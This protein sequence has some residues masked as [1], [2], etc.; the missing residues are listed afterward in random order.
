MFNMKWKDERINPNIGLKW[1]YWAKKSPLGCENLEIESPVLSI[2]QLIKSSW[3]L[4][5]EKKIRE[6]RVLPFMIVFVLFGIFWMPFVLLDD[7][8]PEI[9]KTL[10]LPAEL[11]PNILSFIFFTVIFILIFFVIPI[12]ILYSFHV[13]Q[14]AGYDQVFVE[15]FKRLLPSLLVLF[16]YAIIVIVGLLVFIIPGI[17][18][19]IRYSLSWPVAVLE[20]KRGFNAFKRSKELTTGC[21]W[22]LALRYSI[23]ICFFVLFYSAILVI[24]TVQMGY[25]NMFIKLVAVPLSLVFILAYVFNIYASLIVIESPE[26]AVGQNRSSPRT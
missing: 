25:I 10:G 22:S 12:G 17:Y 5:F 7:I 16:L 21:F 8:L 2:F 23:L 11:L 1:H 24:L 6:N 18:L 15:G 26:P 19:A 20:N 4:T 3:N 9:Y 13:P 14:K